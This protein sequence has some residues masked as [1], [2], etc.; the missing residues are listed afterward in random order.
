LKN[1]KYAEVLEPISLR[2]E[3]AR[4]FLNL[5]AR[6]LEL[7]L[8]PI[9]DIYG[10]T[11]HDPSISALVISEETQAGASAIASLRAEKGLQP[12]QLFVIDVIGDKPGKLKDM[13]TEKMSSTKIRERLSKE[14]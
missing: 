7:E 8:V 10:P 4:K 13:A 3:N 11:A 9:S 12:L 6:N 2:I 5:I 14:H 1:K